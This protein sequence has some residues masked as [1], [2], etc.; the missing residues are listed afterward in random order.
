MG[1]AEGAA[2][3]ASVLSDGTGKEST[4]GS[5]G[6]GG[7]EAPAAIGGAKLGANAGAGAT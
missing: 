5:G 4:C 7:S 3:S 1:I 6:A 2:V